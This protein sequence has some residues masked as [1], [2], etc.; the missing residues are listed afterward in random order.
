MDQV[1][2][3]QNIAKYYS[4]LP[5]NLQQF[6]SSMVW[7]N[8]LEEISK[9]YYLEEKQIEILGTETTL[10]LL[11][12]LHPEEY[13]KTLESEIKI[14][15]EKLDLF[16]L[17][18]NEKIL[19]NIKLEL[20]EAY[21]NNV[22]ELAEEKYG[23]EQ[24]LDERFAKLPI[25]VQEAISKS[26]YQNTLYGIAEKYKLSIEDM[27]ILEEVTT[28][29]M[30][31]IIHPDKYE[32]ELKAQISTQEGSISDLVNDVNEN[33]LKNIRE[34]L[35]RNWSNETDKQDEDE[36]PTPPYLP[37]NTEVKPK[38]IDD[39]YQKSGIKIIDEEKI[40][41][42]S[43]IKILEDKLLTNTVSNPIIKDYSIP[44][45]GNM[46]ENIKTPIFDTNKITHDPYKEEII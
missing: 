29:V 22:M 45:M 25:E 27:G 18:I 16:L 37:V 31:N 15:K 41:D 42:N 19:K 3:Q 26:N 38:N 28:K 5:E 44:K 34:I 13:E 32:E 7:I 10:L 40:L 12:I 1:Q 9:K 2:L 39:V 21:D 6:F 23:K 30:L 43:G 14:P 24:P 4:K 46:K 20:E 36:I 17:E 8:N 33:I 35:K 11:S